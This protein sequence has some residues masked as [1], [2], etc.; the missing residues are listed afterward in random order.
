MRTDAE[1]IKEIKS[2]LHDIFNEPYYKIDA[3]IQQID[4]YSYNAGGGVY[5]PIRTVFEDLRNIIESK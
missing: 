3:P 2:I 5:I 4:D 1:K